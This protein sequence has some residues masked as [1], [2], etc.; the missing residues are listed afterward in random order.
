M[1]IGLI[2]VSANAQIQKPVAWSYAAKKV[3]STEAII[4]LK[5]TIDNGWHI[6][7]T[8][9]KDGGPE[10]TEFKF[11]PSKEYALIGKVTEPKAIKKYEE[12]FEMDV[13]YLER[14]VVFQQRIKLNKSV[15][16]VK[17]K[18]SFMVCTDKECLPASEL[19]FNVPVK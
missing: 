16:V 14:S 8:G 10:K 19:E 11:A 7:S 18:V 1:Q 3:S 12:V 17:G 2:A 15:T 5:A 4:F 6:Y 13:F 9:Q